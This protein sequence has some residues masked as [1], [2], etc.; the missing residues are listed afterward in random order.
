[1]LN[2]VAIVCVGA[3]IITVIGIAFAHARNERHEEEDC[4]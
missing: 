4:P 1:M 2:V 3:V